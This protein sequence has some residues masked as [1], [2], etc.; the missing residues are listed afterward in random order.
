MTKIIPLKCLPLLISFLFTISLFSQWTPTSAPVSGPTRGIFKVDNSLIVFTPWGGVYKS[1]DNGESWLPSNSGLP[2][3]MRIYDMV[4][5]DGTLY[6]SIEN[7]G[8]YISS[9]KGDNWT[10]ISPL[11]KDETSYHI[12]VKGNNIYGGLAYGG[13]IYSSNR[14]ATW[15]FKNINASS[16]QFVNLHVYNSKLYAKRGNGFYVTENNGDSWTEIIVPGISANG[17]SSIT[18]HNDMLF[19]ADEYNVFYSQDAS[20]W[21]SANIPS[22]RASIT[23]MQSYEGKLYATTNN[24]R[25]YYLSEI[26]QEWTLVQRANTPSFI[27][28][29]LFL[30]DGILM[31]SADGIHKSID[32]GT[33]WSTKSS[34]INAFSSL[35]MASNSNYVFVSAG[36]G[37]YRTNDNG[38]NWELVDRGF[39]RPTFRSYS[40]KNMLTV[41]DTIFVSTIGGIY[42]SIDNGDSW[43]PKFL[44]STNFTGPLAYDDGVLATTESG[45]GVVLSDDLGETWR[46][47]G[48]AGLNT[49]SQFISILING[50]IIVAGTYQSEIFLSLDLGQTW[51]E[52]SIPWNQ[53][54]NQR[55]I[56][57]EYENGK[58]YVTSTQGLWVSDNL[59]G[60]WQPFIANDTQYM[61]DVTIID[62]AAY[63]ATLNGVQV[64]TEGRKSWFPLTEGMGPKRIAK[65]F[66]HNNIMFVG[67]HAHGIWTGPISELGVPAP[68][69]DN[70]GVANANDLCPNTAPGIEVNGYGC[71][72]IGP[73]V[74][75]VY[76]AT[77]TCPN[78]N[79]G[80]IEIATSLT[81]YNFDIQIV[82]E[83]RDESFTAI[84]WDGNFEVDDLAPGTY[85]ITVSIPTIL[86]KQLFGVTIEGI[87]SISGKFQGFD[88]KA[89][90]AK[91]IVSG[92][93]EYTVNVNGIQKTYVF[94]STNENEIVLR[95]LKTSNEVLISGKNDCQGKIDDTFA[96]EE[97]I[98]IYPTI[99]AGLLNMSGG[100]KDFEIQVYNS[101][102]QLVLREKNK[103]GEDT[104]IHLDNCTAGLYVVHVLS[105]G[106]TKAFKIIKR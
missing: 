26:G 68:D 83:G 69:D 47:A 8:I 20:S 16:A 35:A 70:D 30:D 1:S 40:I 62:D 106:H 87:N 60:Q 71:D 54:S 95:N 50:N 98:L 38:Q 4:E 82:G 33:T 67:T 72:L 21:S 58:L 28:N 24:G 39:H 55:P 89:K 66:V 104:A 100:L 84:D 43:S 81:G 3:N 5:A 23:S 32:S 13:I 99:T 51:N 49:A 41:S 61:D 74:I 52:I 2:S 85:D 78:L 101:G 63:V 97:E 79:N 96:L 44:P 48:T 103:I 77:P 27:Y 15:E 88:T 94:D 91:Y 80:S 12:F 22:P 102:G 92:S 36:D 29:L 17:L 25:Y 19:I 73:D 10:S 14:G 64:S 57:L 75:S 46:L 34:G 45:T 59:G 65:L 7:Q 53:F 90:S 42:N 9:D 6:A 93:T 11:Q 76:A 18:V 37:V 31:S 86:H 56:D 105:E